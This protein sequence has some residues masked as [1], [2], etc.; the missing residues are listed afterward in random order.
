MKRRS[1]LILA[2]MTAL[3]LVCGSLGMSSALAETTDQGS[4]E[5]EESPAASAQPAGTWK[6]INRYFYYYQDG[7]KLTGLQQIRGNT[8]YFKSNG[9]QLTGWR[10][11]GSDYYFFR[12]VNGAGGY[13]VKDKKING[14]QLDRN[15]KAK[16]NTKCA[17]RKTKVMARCAV[18][19]DKA[20]KPGQT[21]AKKLKCAYKYLKKN[22]DRK[23]VV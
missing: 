9:V 13:M 15:G 7:K 19:M 3:F 21:K 2:L 4:A 18:L 20:V 16:L 6:E 23:S 22:L 8:Y 11:I 10:K 14:I 17:K 1:R 12:I 5:T